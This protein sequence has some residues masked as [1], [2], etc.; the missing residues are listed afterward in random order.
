VVY[1]RIFHLGLAL[2][3]SAALAASPALA[4]SSHGKKHSSTHASKSTQKSGS[5]TTAK[6]SRKSSA[7]SSVRSASKSRTSAKSSSRSRGRKKVARSRGQQSISSER[8]TEIQQALIRTHYLDGE[9]SGSWDTN[10]QAAMRRLQSEHGWQTKLTPDSR[11]LKL[12]GLGPDYSDAINAK[13]AN[14]SGPI[15]ATDTIPAQQAAGFTSA[16]GVKN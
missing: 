10:T 7:K 2:I 8:A 13:G 16:S 11:A 4:A 6:S 12:L 9:P 14:F 5:K 3:L 15:N 1:V